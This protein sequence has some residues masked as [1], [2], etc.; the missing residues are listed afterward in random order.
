MRSFVLFIYLSYVQALF[1]LY[2]CCSSI[3]RVTTGN[4]MLVLP[5]LVVVIPLTIYFMNGEG[6]PFF[7]R[8]IAL[9]VY[10]AAGVIA[11]LML[12]PE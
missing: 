8:L 7:F 1:L 12:A 6:M 2:L 3:F 9:T 11:T 10:F 5:T 4:Y